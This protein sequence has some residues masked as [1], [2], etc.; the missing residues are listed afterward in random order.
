[1]S[2]D[3][4]QLDVLKEVMNIGG[5]NAATSISSMVNKT[6]DMKVPDVNIHNFL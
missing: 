2:Y 1:M 6:I 5:G 3:E 4:M